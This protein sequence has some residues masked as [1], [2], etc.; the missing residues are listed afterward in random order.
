MPEFYMRDFGNFDLLLVVGI[1]LLSGAFFVLL[2]WLTG[3]LG[4]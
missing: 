1:P 3:K 2:W 4:R